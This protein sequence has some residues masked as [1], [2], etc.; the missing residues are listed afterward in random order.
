[1][2]FRRLS[3]NYLKIGQMTEPSLEFEKRVRLSFASV[4]P[5]RVFRGCKVAEQDGTTIVRI[6]SHD[7]QFPNLTPTPY[8]LFRFDVAS[9]NLS[10]LSS[11]E[12]ALFTIK[13]YK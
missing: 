8:Q 2:I 7:P 12:A 1:L 10:P 11:E 5:R 4:K 3:L 13:N 9:G 6:Y